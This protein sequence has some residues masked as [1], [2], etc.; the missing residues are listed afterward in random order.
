MSEKSSQ[1]D[2]GE[3]IFDALMKSKDFPID[4]SSKE[5]ADFAG[6]IRDACVN[7]AFKKNRDNFRKEVGRII[8]N[9]V[10][11]NKLE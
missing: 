6:K 1:A 4:L 7:N 10:E 3:I 8:A 11:K 2:I 5:K 9:T